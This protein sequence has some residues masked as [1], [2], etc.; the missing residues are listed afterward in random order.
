MLAGDERVERG[1]LERRAQQPVGVGE[2]F[3]GARRRDELGELTEERELL[4]PDVEPGGVGLLGLEREI[5]GCGVGGLRHRGGDAG[6]GVGRHRGVRGR[7]RHRGRPLREWQQLA[8][9]PLEADPLHRPQGERDLEDLLEE[10]VRR[11]L[12]APPA[13]AVSAGRKLGLEVV[14]ER[15]EQPARVDADDDH[16]ERE[17]EQQVDGLQ[18]VDDLV[19]RAAVEVVDVEDDALDVGPRAVAVARRR[20]GRR[21]RA[22]R[23][24]Q[25]HALA[26]VGRGRAVGE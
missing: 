23:R 1:L 21:S 2:P 18:D 12:P 10:V 11:G 9:Q 7:A 24:E 5:R 14:L 26:V 16:E 3:G 4:R 8:D 15:A 19:G 17:R 20:A 22:A 6:R 25:A 13:G